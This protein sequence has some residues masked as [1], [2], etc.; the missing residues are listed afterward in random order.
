MRP[1]L[2]LNLFILF[3]C[4]PLMGQTAKPPVK[5]PSS[6]S[7]TVAPAVKVKQLMETAYAQY[8]ASNDKACGTTLR[9]VLL[10]DPK[11]QEAYLLLANLSIYAANY[12][13]MWQHLNT[14]Y[15]YYPTQPE[16]YA[17][18]AVTHLNYPDLSDSI[19]RV[20]CRKTIVLAPKKSDGYANLGMVALAGGFY[21]DALSCFDISWDKQWSDTLSRL[22]L[23]LFYARCLYGT[24]DTSAAIQRLETLVPKIKGVDKYTA[25]FLLAKYKLESGHTDVQMALDTLNTV[26]EDMPDVWVIN[27]QY[28]KLLNFSDS[29]CNVA[30]KIRLFEGGEQFDLSPYCSQI[31]KRIPMPNFKHLLYACGDKELNLYLTTNNYPK[32][33]QFKWEQSTVST[34][35]VQALQSGEVGLSQLALDSAIVLMTQLNPGANVVFDRNTLLYLSQYQMQ[36]LAMHGAVLMAVDGSDMSVFR[37]IGHLQIEVFDQNNKEMLLDCIG[38]SDGL[39]TLYYLDDKQNPLIVKYDIGNQH[40]VLTKFE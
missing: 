16:I 3:V 33:I 8:K 25:L 34:T 21:Q 20:L 23:N 14:I 15:K 11:N 10:L 36:Q 12:D 1:L 28:L 22:Y 39:N 27:A 38:L 7:A 9:Q 30:K 24:G 13:D 32:A 5:K 18:F 4:A 17:K 26:A 37:Q 19:K 6:S 2:L 40:Y 29:A 31:L 35:A